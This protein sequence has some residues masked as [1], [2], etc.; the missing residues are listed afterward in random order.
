MDK[1]DNEIYIFCAFIQNF[2]KQINITG[3][4]WWG[5]QTANTEMRTYVLV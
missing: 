1:N 2:A 4:T 3:K 5:R